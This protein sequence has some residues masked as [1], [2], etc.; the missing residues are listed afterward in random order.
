MF[1]FFLN[2]ILTVTYSQVQFIIYRKHYSLFTENHNYKRSSYVRF[3]NESF[4]L[5]ESFQ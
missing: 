2:A 3:V 4:F 1:A 5:A